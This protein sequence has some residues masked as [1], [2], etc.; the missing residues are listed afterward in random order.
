MQKHPIE[1]APPRDLPDFILR[2]P[3]YRATAEELLNDHARDEPSRF[4]MRWLI[5][6]ADRVGPADLPPPTRPHPP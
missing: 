5:E 6:L 4:V 1:A 3:H 2:W